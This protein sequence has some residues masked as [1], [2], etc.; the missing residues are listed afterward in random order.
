VEQAKKAGAKAEHDERQA[1]EEAK[2]T[3]NDEEGN[4]RLSILN[5]Y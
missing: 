2:E 4:M 5:Q 3:Q 1:D